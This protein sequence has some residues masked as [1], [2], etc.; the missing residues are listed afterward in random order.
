MYCKSPQ[1][2]P[3]PGTMYYTRARVNRQSSRSAT[4]VVSMTS[5]RVH[6][7]SC[8][9]NL[10]LSANACSAGCITL[11]F[12]FMSFFFLILYTLVG[13]NDILSSQAALSPIQGSCVNFLCVVDVSSS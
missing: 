5:I 7:A 3:F 4:A 8:M 11:H 12:I 1:G 2:V 6:E 10:D 13:F 9:F